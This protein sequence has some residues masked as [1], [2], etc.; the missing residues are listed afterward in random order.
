MIERYVHN[1]IT[2]LDVLKP[3]AEELRELVNECGIPHEFAND[4][5]APT[6]KTEVYW[7]KDSLKLALDF[8]LVKRTNINRPHEIKFLVTKTH[9]VTIRFDNIEAIHRF[10]KEFEVLCMLKHDKR[11]TSPEVLFVTMLNFLYDAMYEAVDYLEAKLSDIEDEIFKEHEKEMVFELSHV[12]RR[13]ISFRQVI[14]A[15]ENALAKLQTA[16][17]EAF[18]PRGTQK[19]DDLEHHYRSLMRRVYALMSMHAD[20]RDTNNALLSTKQNEIMK[21]FTILAF[22]TFPLTL[23]TSTFGMNTV[24]TPILGVTHDFWI[25]VSIMVVVSISFFIFF[26]YKKWM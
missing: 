23:F 12:S 22:I 9:F 26:K 6:P 19:I 25:I 17:S 14:S 5:G 4:L 10:S 11:K 7:K 16:L 13:L 21:M 24:S 18:G 15:H 2:W 8:P 20:L 3:T 1:N